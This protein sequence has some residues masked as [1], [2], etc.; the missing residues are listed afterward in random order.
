M[1]FYWDL[2][3]IL[4]SIVKFSWMEKTQ[5]YSSKTRNAWRP[6]YCSKCFIVTS[7]HQVIYYICCRAIFSTAVPY[8]IMLL[9]TKY[10]ISSRIQ[11]IQLILCLHCPLHIFCRTC[12]CTVAHA[13][14]QRIPT[15]ILYI[16]F[17]VGPRNAYIPKSITTRQ[18]TK[19]H[20]DHWVFISAALICVTYKLIGCNEFSWIQQIYLALIWSGID[21]PSDDC[22]PHFT[23]HV[24]FNLQN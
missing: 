11:I 10:G 17:N 6:G 24:N 9:C 15:G 19:H 20:T 22:F 8:Q 7:R 4:L 14:L 1:Y 5:L 12:H 13:K 2:I 23:S 3:F 21:K 18:S 16:Q